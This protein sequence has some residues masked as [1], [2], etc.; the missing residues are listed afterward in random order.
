MAGNNLTADIIRSS[1][2][3]ALIGS[4]IANKRRAA[5]AEQA[6][7][8][9]HQSLVKLTNKYNDLVKKLNASYEKITQ[10]Q[11][12]AAKTNEKYKSVNQSILNLNANIEGLWE[13][14]KNA[15]AFIEEMAAVIRSMDDLH[16]IL[17]NPNAVLARVQQSSRVNLDKSIELF[18]SGTD[19]QFSRSFADGGL[20]EVRDTR[21]K[22][23]K[24]FAK[25]AEKGE[26]MIIDPDTYS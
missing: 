7:D 15:Y 20:D 16:P 19:E 10:I 5:H 26:A 13:D 3:G 1:A 22:R 21:V 9:K 18:K 23:E 12:A 25:A 14:R 2:Q 17:S 4:N 24:S 11:D 6:A 8:D